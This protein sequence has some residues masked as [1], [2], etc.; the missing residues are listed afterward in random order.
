MLAANLNNKK[1]IPAKIFT[2]KGFRIGQIRGDKLS[3]PFWLKAVTGGKAPK[4]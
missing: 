2:P 4:F 1:F 3:A